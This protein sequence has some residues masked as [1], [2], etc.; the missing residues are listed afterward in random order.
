MDIVWTVSQVCNG[1]ILTPDYKHDIKRSDIRVFESEVNLFEFLH[2]E[3]RTLKADNPIEEIA[4]PIKLIS[5]NKLISELDFSPR[6][7]NALASV[8]VTT[9]NQLT[10]YSMVELFKIKNFGRKTAEEI[11][12]KLDSW[13][14]IRLPTHPV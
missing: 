13:Y 6:T 11:T 14:G 3:F 8:G 1:F 9:I 7:I 4:T 2:T 5:P 10:T 12:T